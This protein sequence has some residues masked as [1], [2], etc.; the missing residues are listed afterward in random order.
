MTV[1]VSRLGSE[2]AQVRASR[3]Y[4]VPQT[5]LSLQGKPYFNRKRFRIAD[6]HHNS[7]LEAHSTL[8]RC[9]GALVYGAVDQQDRK[10][11]NWDSE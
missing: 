4:L 10:N 5:V 6:L 11:R 2:H 8:S 7:G 9:C 3:F 1:R